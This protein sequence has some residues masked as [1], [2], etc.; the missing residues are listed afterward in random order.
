M[1]WFYLAFWLRDK[2]ICLVFSALTS[3]LTS[4]L[5]PVQ[6][7]VFFFMVSML[8]PIRFTSPAKVRSGC[9]PFHFS[10]TWFFYTFLK[11]YSKAKLKGSDDKASRCFR[12]FLVR[13]LSDK[14]LPVRSLLHF[15]FKYSLISLLVSWVHQNLWEYCTIL[16]S[17]LNT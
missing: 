9:F 3:G 17:W 2:N 15:S 13:K 4:L 12:P 10:P 16:L 7:A 6:A 14:C 11:A 8:S 1:S 5:V